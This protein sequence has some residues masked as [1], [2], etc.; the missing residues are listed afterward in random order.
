MSRNLI[1]LSMLIFAGGFAGAAVQL[2]ENGGFEADPW[3]EQFNEGTQNYPEGWS[4]W[5][6]SG[7]HVTTG[8]A[9]DVP[10]ILDEKAIT[11]YWGD[12]GVHQPIAASEGDFFIFTGQMNHPTTDPYGAGGPL[13]GVLSEFRHGILRIEFWTGPWDPDPAQSGV[14]ISS[15]EIGR[16]NGGDPG[17][18]WFDFTG[19]AQAP[20]G[21]GEVR[22]VAMVYDEPGEVVDGKLYF[23]D[24]AA[25]APDARQA[26]NPSPPYDAAVGANL[27]VLSWTAPE[28][29]SPG[30][31]VVCDVWLSPDEPNFVTSNPTAAKFVDTAESVSLSQEQ[32]TLTPDTTYFWR[33]DCRDPSVGTTE[34]MVWTFNTG[35]MPPTVEAGDDQYVWIYMSDG[36]GDDT[37]V[38]VTLSG[39]IEDDGKSEVATEW[40]LN[41]SETAESTNVI[42]GDA[43]EPQTTVSID[44]TGWFQ[45]LLTADDSVGHDEDIV[46]VGVYPSACEAAKGDPSDWYSR[47]PGGLTGDVNN[48]CQTN[49]KD[50]AIVAATWLECMSEKLGCQL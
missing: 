21:T 16:T 11:I 26:D 20:A 1:V 22:F 34:G 44:N 49:L 31:T 50:L 29:N 25:F 13:G 32:F 10:Y 43:A 36:D 45:F 41:Y 6:G 7:W 23:D 27:D 12:T 24:L 30:D 14:L 18:T 39:V 47:Y 28:P 37:K 46:H 48:D 35:D 40:T 17:E 3:I 2:L 33:V 8:N 5:G 42:I 9:N 38:T 4:G 19:G 15:V